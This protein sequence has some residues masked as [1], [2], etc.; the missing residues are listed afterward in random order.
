MPIRSMTRWATCR[1]TSQDLSSRLAGRKICQTR[2]TLRRRSSSHSATNRHM[3]VEQRRE[4]SDNTSGQQKPALY[5]Q[6][7]GGPDRLSKTGGGAGELAKRA[8][9]RGN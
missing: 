6:A 7:Q 1:R 8:A 4:L 5:V 9:N 3:P 2:I